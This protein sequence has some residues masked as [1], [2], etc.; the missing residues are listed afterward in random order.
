MYGGELVHQSTD[1]YG[2]IEVIDF[3]H[4][5]RSLHFGNKTQQSAMLLSK[6]FILVHKYAQAMMLPLSWKKPHRALILGLGSGSIARY[7]YN[8]CPDLVI[9]AVELRGEVIDLAKKYFLLPEP[10]KRFTVYHESA[11]DWL[12]SHPIINELNLK[13]PCISPG[14]SSETLYDMI[15]VDMFLTTEVGVDITIN[16][17]TYIDKLT[18][19]LNH[20]GILILNQLGNNIHS[21]PALD[22]L[23]KNFPNQLYSI[24]IEAL[25]TIFIASRSSIPDSIDKDNFYDI[26]ISY[27]LPFRNYF[28]KM[29]P[30]L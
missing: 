1:E 29:H 10:D 17:A 21:Y 23:F 7:L 15:F 26:E 14:K 9:D 3:Q 19:I 22:A 8:Y 24:D 27:M 6:P 12:N 20:D 18:T 16:V 28:E 11:F 2:Q 4:A 25:N 30:V 5:L 13:S